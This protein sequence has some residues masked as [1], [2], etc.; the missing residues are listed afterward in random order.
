MP[1][2]VLRKIIG[3]QRKSPRIVPRF[4]TQ[5]L[6]AGFSERSGLDYARGL[7]RR[8]NYCARKVLRKVA[9]GLWI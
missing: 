9:P 5:P 3:E 8:G 2:L 7:T 4:K 6:I 1:E